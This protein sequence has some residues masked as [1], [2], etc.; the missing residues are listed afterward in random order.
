MKKRFLSILLCVCMT[1]SL[2]PVSA[3]AAGTTYNISS[4]VPTIN[5]GNSSAYNNAVI[6]G[7]VSSE[8]EQLTIDGVTV[9]LTIEDLSITMTGYRGNASGITLQNNATLNLTVKG[10]C[11]LAL[12]AARELTCL[13]AAR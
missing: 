7:T 3:W 12:M 5:S 6:T 9:S 1:L 13:R 11:L 10:T 4:G 2:L 8:Y